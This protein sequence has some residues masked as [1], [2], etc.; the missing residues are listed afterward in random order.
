MER[1]YAKSTDLYKNEYSNKGGEFLQ[2]PSFAV[3][4][5]W[6]NGRSLVGIAGTNP[7]RGMFVS[8]VVCCQVEVSASG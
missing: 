5:A 8:Y 7:A 4:K 1:Y 2:E 3:F 6:V